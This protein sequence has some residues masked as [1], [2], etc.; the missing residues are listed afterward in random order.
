M[1]EEICYI[2][3]SFKGRHSVFYYLPTKRRRG[4]CIWEMFDLE[5]SDHTGPHW[6]SVYQSL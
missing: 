2:L 6:A 5:Q 4:K 1:V 3:L